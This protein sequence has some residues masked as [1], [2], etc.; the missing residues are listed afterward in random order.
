MRIALAI[1]PPEATSAAF[2]VFREPLKVG[3][4]K[5]A[6]LGYDAVEL[7][8]AHA[9]E[10]QVPSLTRTLADAGIGVAAISTGRVFSEAHAWLTSSSR[11]VRSRAVS[12]LIELVEIAGPLGSPRV[13]IGRVRGPIEAG[14]DPECATGRFLDGIRQV[15]MHALP[16]GIDIVLEPVNRY[17]IN[18]VNSAVPDG[19]A[20]VRRI[21]LTNVRLM[22]DTFH[23]NIEDVSIAGSLMEARDV[24]GYLQVADS[25]RWAPGQGHLDFGALV[26]TLHAIRYTGDIGVEILPYPTPDLAA[27]QAIEHLRRFIPAG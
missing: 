13:N 8:L 5:A 24:I 2:V 1:A 21:G 4:G 27:A 23:M 14:E 9:S 15:A 17:E 16:L 12:A 6:S 7:A 19:L 26:S 11:V 20:I 22:P 3:I 25:N 10:V 18:F